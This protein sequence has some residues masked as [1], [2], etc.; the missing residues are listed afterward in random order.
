MKW[1]NN[2]C[3]CPVCVKFSPIVKIAWVRTSPWLL[4]FDLSFTGQMKD[5][6]LA[7]ALCFVFHYAGEGQNTG[8]HLIKCLSSG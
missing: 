8:S 2:E 1:L 7:A 4:N 3:T 5:K 6:W